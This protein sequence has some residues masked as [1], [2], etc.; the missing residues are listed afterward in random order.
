MNMVVYNERIDF[1]CK[2]TQHS[3]YY[4]LE[5]GGWGEY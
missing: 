4:L 3:S 2:L 1:H 5:N